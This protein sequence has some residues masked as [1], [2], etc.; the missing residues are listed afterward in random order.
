MSIVSDGNNR[1]ILTSDST[2]SLNT[3][4]CGAVTFNTTNGWKLYLNGV[5]E[6]TSANTTTFTGTG[7]IQI[8]RYQGGNNFNG[9][10]AIAQIYNR[11]LS[12]SEILQNYNFNFFQNYNFNFL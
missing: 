6:A 2:L 3:W 7:D 8:A 11:V 12:A 1:T 10:I 4:Y 9:K 5:Q